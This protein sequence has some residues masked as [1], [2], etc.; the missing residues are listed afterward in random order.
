MFAAG[1]QV[2]VVRLRMIIHSKQ[3]Q[4]SCQQTEVGSDY[5]QSNNYL[6]IG[7]MNMDR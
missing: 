4:Y 2:R 6:K 7:D 5:I 1:N 3:K